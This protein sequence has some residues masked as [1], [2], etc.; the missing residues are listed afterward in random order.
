MYYKDTTLYNK[1]LQCIPHPAANINRLQSSASQGIPSHLLRNFLVP[2]TPKGYLTLLL[3][4][5]MCIR[6]LPCYITEERNK[7][8]DVYQ[9][10]SFVVYL[11]TLYNSDSTASNGWMNNGK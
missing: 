5:I 9:N 4:E 1:I 11:T 8:I 7:Q 2:R 10:L 3:H 6:D